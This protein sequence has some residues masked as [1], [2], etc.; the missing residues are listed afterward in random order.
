MEE[1]S[2]AVTQATRMLLAAARNAGQAEFGAIQE[3][4][5]ISKL[6]ITEF[7]V[8]EMEKQ[9]NIL[10]LEKELELARFSLAHLRKS[11][12]NK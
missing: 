7:K 2:K 9:T 5:D 4:E 3:P 6:S 8:K 11:Q 1:A 12:Y 10:K